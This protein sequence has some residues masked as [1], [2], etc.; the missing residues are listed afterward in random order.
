M[1]SVSKKKSPELNLQ[2]HFFPGHH[3]NKTVKKE[4]GRITE[5]N[6]IAQEMND[7]DDDKKPK[8]KETIPNPHDL[9]P[10]SEIL[11]L[12]MLWT[13][14][15]DCLLQLE[16]TPDHHAVLVLQPA[17]EAFFLVHSSSIQRIY[18]TEEAEP[19]NGPLHVETAPVSPIHTDETIETPTTTKQYSEI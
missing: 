7:D 3:S 8:I 5:E 17:V 15:S 18:R 6:Q 9:L 4:N 16:L 19:L 1:T 10:L 13:T 2:S 14:L 12:D 11:D